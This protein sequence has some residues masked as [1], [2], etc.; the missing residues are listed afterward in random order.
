MGPRILT[1]LHSRKRAGE[2]H[3]WGKPTWLYQLGCMFS[4]FITRMQL[5]SA[6]SKGEGTG[7]LRK[8]RGGHLE[9]G[10]EMEGY[11]IADEALK[12]PKPPLSSPEDF[13]LA[14]VKCAG[15]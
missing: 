2:V 15:R 14:T 11:G 4:A 13:S 12:G 5:N 6:A 7:Q 1:K 10:N 8:G 9:S 3:I